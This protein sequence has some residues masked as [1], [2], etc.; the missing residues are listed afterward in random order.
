MHTIYLKQIEY[1]TI[2]LELMGKIKN[3]LDIEVIKKVIVMLDKEI[4]QIR[5]MFYINLGLIAGLLILI[6]TLWEINL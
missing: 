4:K 3:E 1:K 5:M 2:K 6:I